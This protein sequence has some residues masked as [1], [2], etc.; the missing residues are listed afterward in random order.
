MVLEVNLVT[1]PEVSFKFGVVVA[2]LVQTLI[3]FVVR[4]VV[5]G[6]ANLSLADWSV[7]FLVTPENWIFLIQITILSEVFIRVPWHLL[8]KADDLVFRWVGS[9][10]LVLAENFGQFVRTPF[11]RTWLNS[12]LNHN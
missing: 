12:D 11:F 9:E 7:L 8:G 5:A 6:V 3:E 10:V 4:P 2:D 1:Y